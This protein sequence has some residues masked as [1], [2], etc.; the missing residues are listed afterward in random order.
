[1][2]AFGNHDLVRFKSR[3]PVYFISND[4][5]GSD[6]ERT[7]DGRE[8]NFWVYDLHR[9]DGNRFVLANTDQPGF[10]KW[11]WFTNKANH[12]E[13]TQLSHEQKKIADEEKDGKVDAR[14]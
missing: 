4:L 10:P 14:R 11:V 1:M 8:H 5:I 7:R 6:G 13:T 12:A 2:Y 9:I 3:G